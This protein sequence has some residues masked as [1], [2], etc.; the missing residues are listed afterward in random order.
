MMP[1]KCPKCQTASVMCECDA[2]HRVICPT[3]RHDYIAP[4]K[5]AFYAVCPRCHRRIIW[6]PCTNCGGTTWQKDDFLVGPGD[7]YCQS[8][9]QGI[10]SRLCPC[11]C[12][13]KACLF[14]W[15]KT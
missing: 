8:C 9:Y 6:G 5:K 12:R 10:A 3:C 4:P 2:G 15:E 11:G 14:N 1:T 7:L 13:I